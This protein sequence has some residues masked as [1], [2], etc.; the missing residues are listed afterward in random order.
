MTRQLRFWCSVPIIEATLNVSVVGK[1]AHRNGLF[2]EEMWNPHA[3]TIFL[4]K[5]HEVARA[6]ATDSEDIWRREPSMISGE[7]NI[8]LR[9]AR[10][11]LS[12]IRIS[13]VHPQ[14]SKVLACS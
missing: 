14:A 10:S 6:N 7:A 1:Q 9:V 3:L 4:W 13:R 11:S 5:G 8:N 12:T 2:R